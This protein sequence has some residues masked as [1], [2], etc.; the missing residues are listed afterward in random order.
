MNYYSKAIDLTDKIKGEFLPSGGDVN[1]TVWMHHLDADKTHREKAKQER[2]KNSTNPV[3]KSWKQH[4]IINSCAA[5]YL[6]PLKL[7]KKKNK[8]QET[9]LKKQWWTH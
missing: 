7:I 9:L 8:T 2:H 5:I 6:L 3:N 4:C 1:T